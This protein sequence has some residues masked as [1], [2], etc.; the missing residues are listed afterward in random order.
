MIQEQE[1]IDI[2]QQVIRFWRKEKVSFNAGATEEEIS[3]FERSYQLSLPPDFRYFYTQVNGMP[4]GLADEW[5]FSLWSL[6]EISK[7]SEG[8][9]KNSKDA[10]HAIQVTFGDY[11]ID[12]YRYLLNCDNKGNWSVI[13]QLENGMKV[14]DNFTHFLKQYLSRPEDICI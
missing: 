12:S 7:H 10:L 4:D 11:C 9:I 13:T 1:F 3:L 2:S 5:L 8:V 6:Q 14:A